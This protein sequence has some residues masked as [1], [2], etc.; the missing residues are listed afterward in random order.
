MNDEAYIQNLLGEVAAQ[1]DSALNQL[2]SVAARA[3]TLEQEIAK[4]KQGE[5]APQE[6]PLPN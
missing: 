6:A 1:R 3:K 5:Q 4:M 2:A